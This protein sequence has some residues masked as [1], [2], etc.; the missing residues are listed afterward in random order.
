MVPSFFVFGQIFWIL[1]IFMSNSMDL[2]FSKLP[3]I[4]KDREAWQS[5]IHG[6]EKSQTQLSNWTTTNNELFLPE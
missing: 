4:V 1:H 6:P 5:A 2:N 3:E